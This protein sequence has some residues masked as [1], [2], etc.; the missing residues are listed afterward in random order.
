[1]RDARASSAG[2]TS[3]QDSRLG[4]VRRA[5]AIRG[6]TVDADRSGAR[7]PGRGP[8]YAGSLLAILATLVFLAAT[9]SADTRI[10]GANEYPEYLLPAGMANLN[11]LAISTKENSDLYALEGANL[12]RV[13]QFTPAGAFVQAFGW[14]IV[15]GAAS[16]TGDVTAGS[17][18]ITNVTTTN[19]S[20]NT[21]Y[22]GGGKII[23][24]PG[25]PANDE[26]RSINHTEIKLSHPAFSSVAGAALAVAAG[27]GN[28]PTN[29]RQRLTVQA[30]GGDFTLSFESAEPGRSSA[31]TVDIPFNAPASGSGSVQEALENLP[32]IGSG[33]V[34]VED[35]SGAGE[36]LITFE[37]RYADTNVRKIS[38]T[39]VSLSGGTP[40]EASITTP[41]EGAGVVETCTTFCL[42]AE[43]EEGT[44][45]SGES[46]GGPAPGQLNYSDEIAVNNDSSS[47]SYGDVY[48]VD[49]RNGRIQKYGP[50]GEFELMFG[51]EVDKTTHANLC[52]TAD[53]SAGDTCGAGVPGSGPGFFRQIS[54]RQSWFQ[55]GQ[56]SIAIGPDGTVYVGD[57]ERIQEFE[58]DG[59]YKGELEVPGAQFVS[60]LA[61]DPSGHVY[62]NAT[63]INEVQEVVKPGEGKEGHGTYTLT[64]KGQTTAPLESDARA[65]EIQTALEA[66]S[67]IGAGGVS[68][69]E[70]AREVQNGPVT[71]RWWPTAEVD[72]LGSLA[73]A[74]LPQMTAS[75]GSTATIVEGGAALLE[76]LG[77]LGEVLQSYSTSG[78]PRH[79]AV[80]SSGDLFTSNSNGKTFR[81]FKPTGIL[82]AA[83]NSDQVSSPQG[84]AIDSAAGKLYSTASAP[85]G[86]HI[87]VSSLPEPG[88]SVVKEEEV[89][90]I[91]PATATLH[92]VVNPEGFDT[93]YHFEY[94][95]QNSFEHEGGFSSPHTI[96]TNS[97]DLGLV[98]EDDAV[99]ASISSLTPG[100]TYHFRAVGESHCNE[101]QPSEVCVTYGGNETFDS[102]Q[103]VSVRNFTTQTVGPI[104]CY[105]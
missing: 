25:I 48:V 11:G 86:S 69:H 38:T 34:S 8:A 15:P 50:D 10:G 104:G 77:P 87:A 65:S 57:F 22:F 21:G 70:Y 56:G 3:G 30:T 46:V 7:S 105:S 83:F 33:N 19:G 31:K 90:N 82:Y 32:N 1:M 96:A 62:A 63:P 24:G 47:G 2:S 5:F 6:A 49:Q 16:G 94:V 78:A 71:E 13:T 59:S 80:D 68:V 95:D 61:V 45:Q 102:L 42:G 66:L 28:V 99:I 75:A 64:F 51:G 26:I 74:N 29:E 67:T 43:A 91:E 88:P 85:E 101:A 103:P 20:F 54:N 14:G 39:N 12:D 40:S 97:T 93:G 98:A 35:G 27:P 76:R 92:A 18:S 53:I 89:T 60:S 100:T 55:D 79:I 4:S 58:P 9:A 72:F 73:S 44:G 52:T 81:A 37:G 23:T 17:N 41:Q 84:I 36:Y